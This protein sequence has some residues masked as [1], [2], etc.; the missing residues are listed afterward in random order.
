MTDDNIQKREAEYA[1]F[2]DQGTRAVLEDAVQKIVETFAQTDA[3]EDILSY[4]EEMRE[5]ASCCCSRC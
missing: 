4:L 3:L 5:N 1:G 2:V